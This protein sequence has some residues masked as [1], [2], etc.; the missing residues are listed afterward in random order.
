[1][2]ILRPIHKTN[3]RLLFQNRCQQYQA[4]I[5][6]LNIEISTLRQ[7]LEQAGRENN[8]EGILKAHAAA[9]QRQAEESRKQYEKCLDDVANQVVRALL[10]QKVSYMQYTVTILALKVIFFVIRLL[11]C[12]SHSLF[13]SFRL[14]ASER[15]QFLLVISLMSKVFVVH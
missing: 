8:P 10:A 5:S 1:M 4:T 11:S 3:Q 12:T 7:Q 2:M 9:L 15:I 13:H 14:W 6:R